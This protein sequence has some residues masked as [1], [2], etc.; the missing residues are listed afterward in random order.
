[1][2]K[3]YLLAVLFFVSITNVSAQKKSAVVKDSSNSA[4]VEITVLDSKQKPRKGELVLLK[5]AK[6]GT[7]YTGRVNASGIC[8][9][10]LPAGD[11]YTVTVKAMNDTTQ[12]GV[13]EIG[14]LQA[15]QYYTDPFK[16]SIT[17]EPARSFTLDNVLFD[18]GKA[19]LK[20]TSYKELEEL[21][22]YL[23][24][25]EEARI[26]IAG[27]TDNVG[28]PADNLLLSQQRAE[29][30]KAYAVKK[31]IKQERIVA[32]GYGDTQPVADNTLETGR[33]Q[34]RRTEVR[35]L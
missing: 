16:V 2:Y 29:A 33:Q 6:G 9:L 13:I 10:R 22:E 12:Y 26:E 27:H 5:S 34:N 3:L 25:K 17:Y 32:K 21:V 7:T 18:V 1:M 19:T 31:G 20:P 11:N 24:W 8:S 4:I 30:V 28:K 15:G 23:K 14:A 35:M